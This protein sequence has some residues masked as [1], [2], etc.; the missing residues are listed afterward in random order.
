MGTPGNGGTDMSQLASYTN[1]FCDS[2]FTNCSDVMEGMGAP[3]VCV[4][5]QA[6]KKRFDL[7]EEKRVGWIREPLG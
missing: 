6:A 2:S 3:G 4:C 5:S 7:Q 1:V